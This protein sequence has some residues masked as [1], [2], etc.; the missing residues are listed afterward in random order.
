VKDDIRQDESD[1]DRADR[2]VVDRRQ[3]FSWLRTWSRPRER[4]E[5]G[6]AILRTDGLADLDEVLAV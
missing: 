2:V 5:Q 4:P 1:N 6:P 3:A